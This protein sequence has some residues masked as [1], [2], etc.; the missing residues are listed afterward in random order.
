MEAVRLTAIQR[1]NYCRYRRI[2]DV[3]V[4]VDAD[5]INVDAPNGFA[6]LNTERVAVK[7]LTPEQ[8]RIRIVYELKF[9]NLRTSLVGQ[10]CGLIEP[11]LRPT[12][13]QV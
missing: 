10:I 5:Y 9:P 12:V 3:A 4:V 13:R 1:S 6:R 2:E 7:N 8:A 11:V